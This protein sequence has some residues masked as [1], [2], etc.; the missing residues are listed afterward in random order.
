MVHGTFLIKLDVIYG[1]R[2]VG[3]PT[4]DKQDIRRYRE[5]DIR[6]I[7]EESRTSY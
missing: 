3:R 4:L 5:I 6:R 2:G 7:P 1:S